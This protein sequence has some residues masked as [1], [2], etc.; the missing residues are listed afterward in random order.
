MQHLKVSLK[1]RLSGKDQYDATVVT[2]VI[3]T[4]YAPTAIRPGLPPGIVGLPE[5]D[6]ITAEFSRNGQNCGQLVRDVQ[7]VLG[8]L[9]SFGKIGAHVFVLV[10]GEIV[11]GDTEHFPK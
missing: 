8:G 10:N 3:D 9:R 11:G 4:C 5:L 7:Q 6:Y 1:L 2:T